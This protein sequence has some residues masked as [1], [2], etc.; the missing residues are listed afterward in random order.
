MTMK[1]FKELMPRVEAL[2]IIDQRIKRVEATEEVA[3]S[4]SNN[5]VLAE[6]VVAGF[7]VPP[8]P[9]ASMDGY[10]VV[11]K[12]TVGSSAESP[13]ALNLVGVQ[14][15]GEI[16]EGT[17]RSGECLEIATG[18][19][20]P[21]GADAV[22]MVEY[23]RREGKKILV[24]R[25]VKPMKNMAKA[26]E[27]MVKGTHVISMGETITPGVLGA[28]AALGYVKVKVFVKPKVAI[29][30]SGPEIAPQG[31]VLKPGQIYDINSL[32]LAAIIEMNGGIPVKRGIVKD[33][34]ESVRKSIEDAEK[35]DLGVFSGGSSVGVKDLFGE[36]MEELGEIYFHGV[37]TKPGKPT[38]F[39]EI[40]GTP[41][42]GMPGYPTSCLN[43]SYVYLIPALRKLGRLKPKHWVKVK[44]P[45]GHTMSSKSNREQFI[46]VRIR[47]DKVFRVYKQSGNITS[48]THADGYIMLPIGSTTLEKGKEVEV[49]LLHI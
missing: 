43:N 41:L 22:V 12:D 17:I 14:H 35:H 32:T 5:R 4:E 29:Y 39:G 7:H 19:P 10:A 20:M 24:E 11:A 8:F 48:M 21:N 44:L 23:T 37:K 47:D 28:L 38:L 15:T 45:M 46:T 34:V 42:F 30:S 1:P 49:T 9:R 27:D 40:N 26:G 36:V 18:A 3:I 2:R 33:T 25:P 6:D 16:Y 31:Q 13:I